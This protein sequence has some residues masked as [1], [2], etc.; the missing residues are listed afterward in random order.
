[1]YIFYIFWMDQQKQLGYFQIKNKY[2]RWI[3]EKTIC[4]RTFSGRIKKILRMDRRLASQP[5]RQ[6]S[7][8]A[9]KPASQGQPGKQARKLA[10][11]GQPAKPSRVFFFLIHPENVWKHQMFSHNFWTDQTKSFWI[12][13]DK[14]TKDWE[15]GNYL[16]SYI[17]WRA[18]TFPTASR[19]FMSGVSHHAS[20]PASHPTS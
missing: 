12:L 13:L 5:A 2:Y 11:W 3:E 15:R 1:M 20:Q 6:A 10:S 8:L 16:F 9:R 17:F 19:C 18:R 14:T 7:K 4:F